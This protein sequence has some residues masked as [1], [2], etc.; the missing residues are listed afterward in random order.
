MKYFVRYIHEDWSQKKLDAFLGNQLLNYTHVIAE[1]LMESFWG[2]PIYGMKKSSIQSELEYNKKMHKELIDNLR[3]YS[4][5]FPIFPEYEEIKTKKEK[6]DFLIDKSG[7]K[8]YLEFLEQRR[9]E[10]EEY[11]NNSSSKKTKGRPIE[12][13]NKIASIFASKMISHKR[14]DWPNIVRLLRW[15]YVRLQDTL[16]G[17]ELKIGD[18]IRKE[19][20]LFIR[21]CSSIIKK[22]IKKNIARRE[23][24]FPQLLRNETTLFPQ[25]IKFSKDSIETSRIYRE[26]LITYKVKFSGKKRYFSS[27][28]SKLPTIE[29]IRSSITFPNGDT[30]FTFSSKFHFLHKLKHILLPSQS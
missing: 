17:S 3:Y 5:K 16:Y 29:K 11:L 6:D 14:P 19:K 20:K 2:Y 25:S 23:I 4:Y 28:V 7:A 12:K 30:F 15:F 26:K 13:K 22:D 24:F 10:L 18:K 8:S 1:V 21:Q 9:E 27:H